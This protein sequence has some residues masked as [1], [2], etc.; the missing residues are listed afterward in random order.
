M[1]GLCHPPLPPFAG[2]S[3]NSGS[4]RSAALPAFLATADP[5][6]SLSPSADFPV[7]GYTAY[8]APPI[9]RRDEDGFSSCSARPCHRAVATT[10]PEWPVEARGGR[11]C[12][13]RPQLAGSAS[14]TCSFRGH[15]CVHSRC[16]PVTRSPS[17]RWLCRWAS[18]IRFPSWLPSKLRGFWFFPR[19]VC[20][21]LNVLAFW[22]YKLTKPE[23]NSELRSLTPVFDGQS[24]SATHGGDRGHRLGQG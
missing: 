14:G 8:L 9:S 19:W 1:G 5:S 10:P 22:P 2:R 15:L 23:H 3:T 18:L 24:G 11:A 17:R 7:S 13:L 6:D 20:L 4:L 16:G 21:P 12:S